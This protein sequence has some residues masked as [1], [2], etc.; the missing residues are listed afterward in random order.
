MIKLVSVFLVLLLVFSSI[1]THAQNGMDVTA[2]ESSSIQTNHLLIDD[3]KLEVDIIID[4]YGKIFPYEFEYKDKIHQYK[5]DDPWYN[6]LYESG[7]EAEYAILRMDITNT[8]TKPRDFLA[9][10]EVKAIFDNVFEYSGWFYQVNYN[11][12]VSD[13]FEIE[14]KNKQNILWPIEPEDF[15]SI[16]PMYQGH[17]IFGCTLPNSVVNSK[18]PLYIV[19]AIDGNEIVYRIRK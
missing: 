7:A 18:Q 6:N 5:G 19:I 3:V 11:N 1:S 4:G 17:Y 9:A 15:Y 10:C 16:D 13:H 12:K 14:D 8:T 2:G